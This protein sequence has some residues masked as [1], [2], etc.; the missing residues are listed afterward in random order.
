MDRVSGR[1]LAETR[2]TPASSSSGGLER[3]IIG[4]SPMASPGTARRLM[5]KKV[6]MM[7]VVRVM[8][9]GGC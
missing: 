5:G 3:H 6:F 9:R 2:D 1:Y 8:I 7:S 4:S